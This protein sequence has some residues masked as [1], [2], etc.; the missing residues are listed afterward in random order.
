MRHFKLKKSILGIKNS[1]YGHAVVSFED[2]IY[3]WGGRND[4]YGP[5][6]KMWRFCGRTHKWSLIQVDGDQP[7]GRD[8]HSMTQVP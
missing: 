8:G 6:D 1:R 5:D 2:S 7:S 3:L 4:Q